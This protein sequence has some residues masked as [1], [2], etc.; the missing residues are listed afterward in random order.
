MTALVFFGGWLALGIV[1]FHLG[2][3]FVP[4]SPTDPTHRLE[5]L[6]TCVF[7]WPLLWLLAGAWLVEQ[8]GAWYLRLTTPQEPD[9]TQLE[10]EREVDRLLGDGLASAPRKE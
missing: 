1:T 6:S 7:A 9:P 5:N 3:R 10:A 2:E 4:N 8:A